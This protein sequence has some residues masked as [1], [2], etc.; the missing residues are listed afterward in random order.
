MSNGAL[1]KVTAKTATEVCKHFQ[2]DEEGKKLLRESMT[3]R[4]FLD[5]LIEKQHYLDA[6]RFLAYALPKR[7]A[8]WWACVCARSVAGGN[9]PPKI[10]AALQAAE[11]WVADPSEENRRSAQPASEGAELGT[12]AGCAAMAVFWSGGSLAPPGLPVVPPDETLTA[13]GAACSVMLAA[14]ATEPGKAPEKHK[15]F[16]LLG[17]D[18]ANGANRW[19]EAPPKK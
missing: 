15:K 14:V 16:V 17:I 19:K 13:H 18:V 9:P 8:I 5:A 10:A 11:K 7:E 3:P 6:I 4:Q 12:A 2:L 1:A